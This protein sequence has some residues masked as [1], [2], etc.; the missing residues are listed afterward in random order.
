MTFWAKFAT[1]PPFERILETAVRE[2]IALIIMGTHGRTGLSR[3]VMGSIAERVTR[4]APC[5]VLTVKATTAEEESWLQ[6]FYATFIR[7]KSN[8]SWW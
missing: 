6:N 1:K 4:L 3:V 2:E 8:Q 5:P 7:P